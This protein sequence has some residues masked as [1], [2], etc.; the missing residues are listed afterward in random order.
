MLLAVIMTLSMTTVA[1]A[2]TD[3]AA[4]RL[5]ETA[6]TVYEGKS[7]TLKASVTPSDYSGTYRWGMDESYT[8]IDMGP[9]AVD[10]RDEMTFKAARVTGNTPAKI[11][12]SVGNYNSNPPQAECLVTILKDGVDTLEITNGG[13]TVADGTYLYLKKDGTLQLG[14]AATS[15]SGD[16]FA[17]GAVTYKW[18]TG[19][20]RIANYST[21]GLITYVAPG[22]T[23]ATVT[24]KGAD[25]REVSDTVNLIVGEPSSITINGPKSGAEGESATQGSLAS[26][27]SFTFTATTEPAEFA[28]H[29]TWSVKDGGTINAETGLYT[30]TLE[31]SGTAT[32]TATVDGSSKKATF[33]VNVSKLEAT[34]ISLK[35][36]SINL[37]IGES[38]TLDYDVTP[39]GASG[40]SL[41]WKVVTGDC[42]TVDQSGK[43]TATKAGSASVGVTLKNS[44]GAEVSTDFCQV[45]VQAATYNMSVSA[46]V[47][48]NKALGAAST[49][50]SQFKAKTNSS[51]NPDTITI[52]DI[53]GINATLL[54]TSSYASAAA[55][56]EKTYSYTDFSSLY[57]RPQQS[58]M[59]YVDYTAAT[60]DGK[61]MSGTIGISVTANTKNIT[62]ELDKISDDYLF[63]SDAN[64]D[65]IP[66]YEIIADTIGSFYYIE[67]GSETIGSDEIGTLYSS[68]STSARSVENDGYS[69]RNI[70]TGYS[71]RKLCFDPT[72][73]EGSF[74]IAYT[75]YDSANTVVASGYL[76]LVVSEVEGDVVVTLDNDDP[77][78]FSSK[79][80][81]DKASAYGLIYDF[82]EENTNYDGD[83]VYIE[84]TDFIDI[85][86]GTLYYD[87]DKD[88]EVDYDERYDMDEV[89]DF[90]FVPEES[91]KYEVEFKVYS[92]STSNTVRASGTLQLVVPGETDADIVVTLD[93]DDAYYFSDD[94]DN[95]YSAYDQIYDFVEDNTSYDG[96][97]VYI[98]FTKFTNTDAGTLYYDD[99]E[100]YEVDTDERY[101][102]DE[103]YDFYFVPE[104][105][106]KYTAE[107]K[108]YS[109]STS[110]IARATGTLVIVVPGEGDVI[111]TLDGTGTYNFSDDTDKDDN[112]A[113]DMILEYLDDA[114][115]KDCKYLRFGKIL[116]GS[117]VGKLYA[118]N[119]LTSSEITSALR[120]SLD[121]MASLS[122]YDMT[123]EAAKSGTFSIEFT[124]YTS[125]STT[126]QAAT[127]VL[128]LIVPGSTTGSTTTNKGTGDV[129]IYLDSKAKDYYFDEYDAEKNTAYDLI[130]DYIYDELKI[131]LED[132]DAYIELYDVVNVGAGTLYADDDNTKLKEEESYYDTDI[133]DFYFAVK[134]DGIYEAEFDVYLYDDKTDEY[135]F[136]EE[137]T[138][139]IIV[140]KGAVTTANKSLSCYSNGYTFQTA[141]FYTI[142]D[143]DPIMSVKFSLPGS[144]KLLVNY[145]NGSGTAVSTSTKF[146][147][148][149]SSYGNYRIT[150]LT[151]IP[152][153]GFTGNVLFNYTATTLKGKTV[154]GTITMEVKSKTASSKFSD[155]TNSHY[156]SWA[157]NAIDFASSW[158]LVNGVTTTAPYKF[159]PEGNMKRCDLLLILYRAAG[160]PAVTGTIT[161]TDVNASDY[162]YKAAVWAVKNG[163]TSGFLTSTSKFAP[164]T[165][166]TREE[167]ATMLYN[168]T[169]YC[170]VSVTNTGSLDNYTD[171]TS[172]SSYA[173]NA[174]TWAVAKGYITSMSTTSLVLGAK[175]LTERAQVATMLH[176]YFTY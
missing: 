124:A 86:A 129:V 173:K 127:G 166:V 147:T 159:E 20:T 99:E 100:D 137:F 134:G 103:V 172:V 27:G 141:D 13:K 28:D 130:L 117:N 41:V 71:I 69:Y 14:A 132:D 128:T 31:Q 151:Y 160:S 167:F 64:S 51:V 50:A 73:K 70:S 105:P 12:V 76:I 59:Y 118:G 87:D 164:A 26:G 148:S 30:T 74:E 114:T 170:G 98:E 34:G 95:D 101:D 29:I 155:V 161:H 106:G 162:Y 23:T 144:G 38:Y 156:G 16:P 131:D 46:K 88:Y 56:T 112:N 107:F 146:Y 169:K 1:L 15:L 47:G 165:T 110:T 63:T 174:M 157:A 33:K 65:D 140:G 176:R 54:Y 6:I 72:G 17:N 149:T 109:S 150:A 58:G 122:V 102:M 123:F 60:A 52:D 108:V 10:Y 79:T 84:F 48:T 126:S 36:E 39:T 21:D 115:T 168:Y 175:N 8:S 53:R 158:G 92:S 85:D 89:Y 37:G 90:Y 142:S 40:H 81:A 154:E 35:N 152:K 18:S 7:F 133:D 49:I 45:N 145:A 91:G 32:V 43:V 80:T 24:A 119:A 111:V 135:E 3:A 66:A 104:E 143:A 61:K 97:A 136:E 55:A 120:F 62:I 82:V 113:F 42:V 77:Y 116:E 19:N 44:A 94:T 96:D 11:T 4:V 163:I 9:G 5:N 125:T 78:Y 121:E 57:L 138:L 83:A 171:A 93:D 67:F 153:A 68:T 2:T 75:A 139:Q 25:G 22:I